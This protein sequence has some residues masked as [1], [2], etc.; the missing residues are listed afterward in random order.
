MEKKVKTIYFVN[1]KTKP[2][3]KTAIIFV[4]VFGSIS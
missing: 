2:D 4:D 3:P 1:Y